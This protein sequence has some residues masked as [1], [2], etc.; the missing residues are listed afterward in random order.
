[1]V[2]LPE[3]L[4]MVLAKAVINIILGPIQCFQSIAMDKA[5]FTPSQ[6]KSVKSV[7]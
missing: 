4:G 3:T 7:R 5:I 2:V 1:M 6:L